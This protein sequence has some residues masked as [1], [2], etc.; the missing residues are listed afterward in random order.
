MPYMQLRPLK[1]NEKKRKPLS[2]LKKELWKVFSAWVK[3]KENR[4]CFTCGRP[5][6]GNDCHGGHFI[7]ASVGGIELYFHEK[8]VHVQCARCNIW[9]D[10]NQ[11]EYGTRL[12]ER[13]V[14]SLRK[15]QQETK[16]KTWDRKTYE[17]KIAHYKKLLT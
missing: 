5:C 4:I 7:K 11:Y 6:D 3:Q 15:I 16:G 1:K 12:G 9:L 14:N 17:K 8:N 2:K 13:T 10:G